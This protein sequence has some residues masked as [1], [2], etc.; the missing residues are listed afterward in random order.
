[1]AEQ[2]TYTVTLS[3]GRSFDVTTEGGPPSEQD[4]LS[5]LD[6][7][8]PARS[9]PAPTGPWAHYKGQKKTISELLAEKDNPFGQAALAA[10]GAVTGANPLNLLRGAWDAAK[11]I[12][13]VATD[14]V[15]AVKGLQYLP[16]TL[17]AIAKDFAG[18][19]AERTGELLGGSVY[20]GLTKGAQ[21]ALE[22]TSPRLM[23]LALQ[24]TGMMRR[25]FPG[26]ARRLVEMG[27]RPSANIDQILAGTTP[28]HRAMAPIEDTLQQLIRE[29][30]AA[31]PPVAGYL[32]EASTAVELGGRTPVPRG[33]RP[34]VQMPAE[35]TGEHIH[36]SFG[37]EHPILSG[38]VADLAK[39]DTVAGRGTVRLRQPGGAPGAGAPASMSDP[40]EIARRARAFAAHE[41]N[42]NQLGQVGGAE[43]E[44][45]DRLVEEYLRMNPRP[46]T[47]T[48]NLAQKRAYGSRAAHPTSEVSP[49]ATN[50]KNFNRGI[51]RAHRQELFRK[52]P[53]AEDA[54]SKEQDLLGA[55]V[56]QEANVPG[57]RT[58]SLSSLLKV[59]ITTGAGLA[60]TTGGAISRGLAGQAGR[61]STLAI[62]AAKTAE[63][64]KLR[65][66]LEA[67]G[68]S[69]QR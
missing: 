37:P 6:K 23:E 45:L 30:D 55:L 1:M 65:A 64:E 33:G 60:A 41:G 40:A 9:A 39:G 31:R 38:E 16:G 36:S 69:G 8:T 49:L 62:L 5:N 58:T 34:S 21:T 29:V 68:K 15:N 20:G 59:P 24:R 53:D 28:A 3:D 66:E 22:A 50:A 14:P 47:A 56:A 2:K 48:E 18:N 54:L 17:A 35:L 7:L 52:L 26:T 57:Y 13:T 61:A 12:G 32:P 51:E 25:D 42:V 11:S 67:L 4:V 44:A 63:L 10:K 27:I 43:S 19:P 46:M